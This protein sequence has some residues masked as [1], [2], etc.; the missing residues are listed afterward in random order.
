LSALFHFAAI[1]VFAL[2]D[3]NLDA[4]VERRLTQ[5]FQRRLSSAST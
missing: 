1:R 5:R 2:A 4:L 3:R